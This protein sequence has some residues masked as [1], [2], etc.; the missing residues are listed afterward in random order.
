MDF[1]EENQTVSRKS[2]IENYKVEF[3]EIIEKMNE[4]KNILKIVQEK[5]V[6][7]KKTYNKLIQKNSKKMFVFSL[8]SF[9]FK[10]KL[11][12]FEMENYSK[13]FILINN[14]MYGDYYKLYNIMFLFYLNKKYGKDTI[15]Q[16][17]KHIP[18][19]D[20][21]P[22]QEYTMEEIENLHLDI[23][24]YCSG[25]SN[26]EDMQLFLNYIHFFHETQNESLLYLSNKLLDFKNQINI[27][28]QSNYLEKNLVKYN[29]STP[30]GSRR[31]LEAPN[32][33][34]ERSEAGRSESESSVS[35][36]NEKGSICNSKFVNTNRSKHREKIFIFSRQ[37]S[38]L[39]NSRNGSPSG[40]RK[41]TPD[42]IRT[43]QP[44]REPSNIPKSR[45]VTPS[46]KQEELHHDISENDNWSKD[47]LYS[48]YDSSKKFIQ[49]NNN[50]FF[51]N[52]LQNT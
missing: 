5:L 25:P 49:K 47:N 27:D 20:L 52:P 4:I 40:I 10:Y 50:L 44:P 51:P 19:K 7:L 1:E 31:I 33:K 29:L 18:Y 9:F 36:F 48:V 3:Q 32:S 30:G 11:L 14:R 35:F 43:I 8:D 38:P 39:D 17:G 34:V 46:K 45:N 2:L 41:I 24:R 13:S 28:N 6:T 23:L 42:S 37:N 26:M 15:Y 16:K 21:E 22:F 12:I